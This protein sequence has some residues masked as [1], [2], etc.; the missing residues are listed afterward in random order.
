MNN[1]AYKYQINWAG[2]GKD[3][4]STDI[5]IPVAIVTWYIKIHI[6]TTLGNKLINEVYRVSSIS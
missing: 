1:D 6:S 3:V 2:I 4:M 5:Q